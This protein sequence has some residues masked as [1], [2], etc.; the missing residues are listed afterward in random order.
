MGD[1]Y[2]FYRD[3]EQADQVVPGGFGDG[4]Q[5]MVVAEHG[6]IGPTIQQLLRRVK[7][8]EARKEI[9]DQ[10]MNHHDPFDA[11]R[12]PRRTVKAGRK[13]QIK[14]RQDFRDF[15]QVPAAD[16]KGSGGKGDEHL[17]E[18]LPKGVGL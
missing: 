10:I 15:Q 18:L 4:D 9:T 5:M 14:L 11:R 13:N 3:L 6:R 2:F 12:N 1:G 16:G 17:P 8:E 7:D